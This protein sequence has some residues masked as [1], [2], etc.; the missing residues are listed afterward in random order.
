MQI[1]YENRCGVTVA[2][3]EATV[4]VGGE[5]A[6]HL[7]DE[8]G[9]RVERETLVVID[10]SRVLLFEPEGVDALLDLER[11]LPERR[12]WIVL[13]GLARPMRERFR[14]SGID[15]VFVLQP[16]SDGAILAA[17]LGIDGGETWH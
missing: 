8:I 4:V 14:Q 1:R 9:E 3:L 6:R 16:E 13:S 17:P 15:G 12:G 5:Q 2:T 10:A 11:R 7:A